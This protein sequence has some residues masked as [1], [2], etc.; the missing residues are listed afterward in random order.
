MARPSQRFSM[1]RTHVSG[2]DR[3]AGLFNRLGSTESGGLATYIVAG[4]PDLE[5]TAKHL[6]ALP[7]AGADLIELGFPFSDPL[8]EGAAIQ[9]AHNRALDAG[10][11]IADVF[12][13]VRRWR[14]VNG[15]TPLLMMGYLNPLLQ[16][17]P[18]E[19]V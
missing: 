17:G 10:T 2:L 4:D 3:L 16:Y 15:E 8:A 1:M 12:G 11:R 5:T 14:S 7:N 6:Q 18:D 13:L 9:A 19:F